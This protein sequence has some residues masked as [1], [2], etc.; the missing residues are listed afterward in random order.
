MNGKVTSYEGSNVVYETKRPY[1]VTV[2]VSGHNRIPDIRQGMTPPDVYIQNETITGTKTYTGRIIKIGA[3]VTDSKPQGPVVIKA[4][5][6]VNLQGG[7][8]QILPGTTVELGAEV[9]IIPQQ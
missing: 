3:N 8:V 1:C 6:R 9:N 2:C 7:D 5:A 4:G